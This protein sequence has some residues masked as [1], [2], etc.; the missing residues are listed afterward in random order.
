MKVSVK[1]ESVYLAHKSFHVIRLV[2]FCQSA[3]ILT[4]SSAQGGHFS[5]H[6]QEQK[7]SSSM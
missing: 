5:R 3:F 7:H 2:L 4:Q 1:I 6:G